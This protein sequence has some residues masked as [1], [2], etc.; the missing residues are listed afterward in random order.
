MDIPN[1]G[2][3]PGNPPSEPE[4]ASDATRT[5]RRLMVGMIVVLALAAIGLLIV[6]LLL[7]RQEDEPLRSLAIP[8]D[9]PLEITD[10][11][12][13]YGEEVDQLL[14]KPLAVTF[15]AEENL[16]ISDTGN[17]RVLAVDADGRLLR[18]VGTDEGPGRLISPYGLTF[19]ETGQRLYVADWTARFV[20]VYAADGRYV[21][22]FPADDQDLSVFGENGFTPFH[23][24]VWDAQIIVSSNDGLYFFD[25]TGHVTDKWGTRGSEPGE[26]AFIDS[27]DVDR[28]TGTFYIADTLNRRVVAMGPGGELQ[29]ISGLPDQAGET[30]GFWQLPRSIALGPDGRL[31]VVDTFRAQEKC[32]GAGHIIVLEANGDLI[33]EFGAAGGEEWEFRFPEKLAI[34]S[35]G[36]FGL[37]DREKDRAVVFT[38]GSLGPVDAGELDNYEASFQRF[39]N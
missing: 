39:G 1:S 35:D 22:R 10:V 12:Y 9:C 14:S 2:P 4:P 34:S 16:W 37:A 23:V 17:S 3:G 30:T 33:A 15:D 25:R 31:Y 11:I 38:V 20:F 29:W 26:F 32:S 18:I 19:D 24:Q 7:L 36:T 13:G 8:D 6:L 5:T 28:A 21:E 27:F